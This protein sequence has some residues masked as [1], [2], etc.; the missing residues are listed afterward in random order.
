MMTDITSGVVGLKGEGDYNMAF[1]YII[2][3]SFHKFYEINPEEKA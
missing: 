2:F 3:I 1:Y